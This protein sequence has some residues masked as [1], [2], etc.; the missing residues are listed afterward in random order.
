MEQVDILKIRAR[1]N[2][3]ADDGNA[4]AMSMPASLLTFKLQNR[5]YAIDVTYVSEVCYIREIT[6]IPG[7]PAFVSG[8]INLRGKIVP[9]ISLKNFFALEERGLTE[10]NRLIILSHLDISFGIICD[11]I[12]DITTMDLT[13]L[14]NTPGNLPG[15]LSTYVSGIFPDNTMLI[16]ANKLTTSPEIT[17]NK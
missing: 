17:I 15:R 12:S 4:S 8:V 11:S 14:E 1:E 16:D 6:S 7:S 10:Q 9:A 5:I 13:S 2:A 3:K